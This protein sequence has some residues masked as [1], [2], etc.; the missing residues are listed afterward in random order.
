MGITYVDMITGAVVVIAVG[1]M[2]IHVNMQRGVRNNTHTKVVSSYISDF[3]HVMTKY[4]MGHRSMRE[5]TATISPEE[6]MGSGYPDEV[7]PFD[8]D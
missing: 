5:Y 2:C 1:Y 3:K 4:P 6:S 8:V 7:S